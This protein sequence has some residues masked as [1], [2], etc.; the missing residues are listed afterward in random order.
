MPWRS[1]IISDNTTIA[2]AG[3]LGSYLQIPKFTKWS[4]HENQS[5]YSKG[6]QLHFF[7]A[8]TM[9][10]EFVL[11]GNDFTNSFLFSENVN[12]LKNGLDFIYGINLGTDKN[13]LVIFVLI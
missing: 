12:Y 3:E 1:S 4:N 7:V 10:L 5:R 13:I 2:E 9:N 8:N 6:H 11:S